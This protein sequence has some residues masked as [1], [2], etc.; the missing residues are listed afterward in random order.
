MLVV[1]QKVSKLAKIKNSYENSCNL[2]R[3]GKS[4]MS[5]NI[6]IKDLI[7]REIEKLIKEFILV[8]NLINDHFKTEIK[9]LLLMDI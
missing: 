3:Q 9:N 5:V 6:V 7:K 1:S 2:N 8:K 4:H